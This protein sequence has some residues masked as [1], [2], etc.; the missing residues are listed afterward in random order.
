ML[1]H[2]GISCHRV[3]F[4]RKMN[5]RNVLC[6]LRAVCRPSLRRRLQFGEVVQCGRE[7]HAWAHL[8]DQLLQ[9]FILA[10]QQRNVLQRLEPL[11][12]TPRPRRSK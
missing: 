8:W 3:A 2:F 6:R 12:R 4:S 9:Q 1:K 11:F 7:S 10:R 5:M